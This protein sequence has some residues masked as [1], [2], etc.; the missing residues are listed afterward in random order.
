MNLFICSLADFAD[1]T[2][3]IP[4][5]GPCGNAEAVE[6]LVGLSVPEGDKEGKAC[7]QGVWAEGKARH[8]RATGSPGLL[9]TSSVLHSLKAANIVASWKEGVRRSPRPR[10]SRA[11]P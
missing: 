3:P 9:G 6:L 2:E 8:K 4:D 10:T 11:S 7:Q 5:Q 1:E